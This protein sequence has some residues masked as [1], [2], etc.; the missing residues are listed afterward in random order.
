M[1]GDH[2]RHMKTQIDLFTDTAA[3]MILP[4]G[5]PIVLIQIYLVFCSDNAA[6]SQ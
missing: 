6:L 3:T 2:S 4:P 5:H 1:V